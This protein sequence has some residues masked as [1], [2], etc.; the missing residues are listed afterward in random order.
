MGTNASGHP[1]E[2]PTITFRDKENRFKDQIQTFKNDYPGKWEHEALF[3]KKDQRLNSS[4]SPMSLPIKAPEADY[5]KFFVSK[6]ELE[7]W[8]D[9]NEDLGDPFALH[10][11]SY[12]EPESASRKPSELP[13]HN[14]QIYSDLDLGFQ[15]RSKGSRQTSEI[16][17]AQR[18]AG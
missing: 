12:S 8:V 9:K 1:T 4:K 13:S 3:S 6:P 15:H 5:R 17:K 10:E 2:P 16:G 11:H 18:G 14:Y 7:V